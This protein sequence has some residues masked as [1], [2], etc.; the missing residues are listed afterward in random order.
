[1]EHRYGCLK[2]ANIHVAGNMLEYDE[3]DLIC[4]FMQAPVH[5]FNK[6]EATLRNLLGLESTLHGR[7]VAIIAGDSIGDA[8]ICADADNASVLRFGFLHVPEGRNREEYIQRYCDFFDVVM[9]EE[10][11]LGALHAVAEAYSRV[12]GGAAAAVALDTF[13]ENIQEYPSRK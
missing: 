1:M 11:S 8:A 4:G 3:E 5:V 10:K 6:N 2:A 12:R 13:C 7:D 9:V